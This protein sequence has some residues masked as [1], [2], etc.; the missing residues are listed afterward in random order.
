[1]P[2]GYI[3]IILHFL[4]GVRMCTF[5][6]IKRFDSDCMGI[7]IKKFRAL[8]TELMWMFLWLKQFAERQL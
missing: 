1:M 6:Q 4:P 5:I 8:G 3:S 2:S 7:E